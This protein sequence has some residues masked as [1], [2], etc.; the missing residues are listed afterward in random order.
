MSS[1]EV[2]TLN[3]IDKDSAFLELDFRISIFSREC[4]DFRVLE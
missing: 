4:M 2:I 1:H 3:K